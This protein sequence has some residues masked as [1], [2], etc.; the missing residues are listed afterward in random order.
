M[1]DSAKCSNQS[2]GSTDADCPSPTVA[3]LSPSLD[4]LS[5]NGDPRYGGGEVRSEGWGPGFM[6]GARLG[7]LAAS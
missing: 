1:R 7:R 4:S 5:L 2:R 3:A 6:A